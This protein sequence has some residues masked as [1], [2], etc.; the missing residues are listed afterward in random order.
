LLAKSRAV[1]LSKVLRGV[2]AVIDRIDA[3][4]PP[5]PDEELEYAVT[6]ALAGDPVTSWQRIAA[7]THDG[8]VQ[9]S[10]TVDSDAARR[11]AE[12]DA[13]AVPGVLEVA[14]DLGVL[15]ILR[16][17]AA[18]RA[19][20]ERVLR[21]D[22]WLDARQIRVHVAD[23]SVHL[24]GSVASASEQS[25]AEADVRA[26]APAGVDL[27]RLRIEELPADN[28]LRSTPR[29]S[30]TDRELRRALFDALVR[31]PRTS[32][33]VPSIE[34]QT[35][36]FVL[37]GIAPNREAAR[38]VDEDARNVPGV[39]DVHDDVKTVSAG[40]ERSDREIRDSVAQSIAEDPQLRSSLLAIAVRSG[41][42]LLSGTVATQEDRRRAIA[43][44]ASTPGA[45]AVEDELATAPPRLGVT[46]A[47][48]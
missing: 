8:R 9:L 15:P 23:G 34:V 44:A 4:A 47:Q 45:L 20:A 26:A 17:E 12:W 48:H 14:N 38:A 41:R 25:R 37:T 46:S 5:R 22:P 42:V 21:G 31:D 10:G 13:S 32:S 40:F 16:T 24:E 27:S 28:S 33:F 2:R 36:V 1:E 29:L 35:H 43:I 18:L 7:S 6:A 30:P 19:E 39:A 11:V 3:S